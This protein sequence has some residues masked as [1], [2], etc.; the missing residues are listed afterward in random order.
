MRALSFIRRVVSRAPISRRAKAAGVGVG[1]ALFGLFAAIP[2]VSLRLAGIIGVA[3]GF[4][5]ILFL[6]AVWDDPTF[7]DDDHLTDPYTPQERAAFHAEHTPA[8]LEDHPRLTAMLNAGD[9]TEIFSGK[10]FTLYEGRRR[11]G[12]R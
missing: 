9:D 5:A 1:V 2:G 4:A 10:Y 12:A 11:A 8:L 6:R 3:F 7:L